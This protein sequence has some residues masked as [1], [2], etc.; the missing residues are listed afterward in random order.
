MKRHT[1][2][3]LALIL[4]AALATG[5]AA[6]EVDP[7]QMP[8]GHDNTHATAEQGAADEHDDDH[9]GDTPPV[10]GAPETDVTADALRFAPARLE[11]IAGEPVNLTLSSQDMFHD[12]VIDEVDFHLGAER[13][14]TTTGGLDGLEPGTYLAYCSVAGHREAGMELEVVVR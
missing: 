12:L 5:C 10:G 4:V 6:F 14:E 3:T 11:L 13:D 8:N 7:D 9:A 2:P 1:M